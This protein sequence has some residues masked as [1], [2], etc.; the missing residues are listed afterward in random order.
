MKSI[1]VKFVTVV[2]MLGIWATAAA[3]TSYREVWTCKI[4]EGKTIDDVR[5]ANSGWVKFINEN[6]DGGG[7]TSHIVTS[8]VGDASEGSFIYVDSF[9][10]LESWAAAKS[11][12]E[13][14]EEGEA[15]DEALGEAAECSENRLL[16]A[17]ES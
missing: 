12:T 3:D 5:A 4:A 7:I 11:A 16:E 10:T 13:G 1:I 2:A 14:N 6:V 17:E 8:V 9:P 15:I